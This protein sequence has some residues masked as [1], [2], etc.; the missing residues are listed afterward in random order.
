MAG[1]LA[2][3]A[4]EAELSSPDADDAIEP[5]LDGPIAIVGMGLKAP[6]GPAGNLVGKEDFWRFVLGGGDAIREDMPEERKHEADVTLPGGL[7]RR[8]RRLRRQ[9][10]RHVPRGGRAHGLP[11]G[12]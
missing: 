9:L 2:R 11:P 10:L 8:A 3:G 7:H 1:F 4:D 6:G 12:R 5:D